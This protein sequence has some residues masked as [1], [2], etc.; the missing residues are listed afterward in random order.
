ML[1]QFVSKLSDKEKRIFYIAILIV[2][3]AVLDRV[4]LGPI[5]GKLKDI[6][7]KIAEQKNGIMRDKRLL[8]YKDKIMKESDVFDKYISKDTADDDL[9]NAGFL[10]LVEKL[11]T[12][13]KVNLIKSTP[14]EAKKEKKYLKYYTNLDCS[15]SFA[16]VV[17]F[18]HAINSSDDLLKIVKFNLTPKRGT[19]DEVNISMSV[20][21]FIISSSDRIEEKTASKTK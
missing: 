1:Q 11:A 7:D 8:S 20:M 5:L 12:E 3:I 9:V 4:F 2:S 18:M 21:K 14:A 6:D 17:S 19:V 10:R 15:G 13:S 16:D